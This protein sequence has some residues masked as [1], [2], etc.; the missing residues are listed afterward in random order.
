[1][2]ATDFFVCF[3]RNPRIVVQYMFHS[4]C[5]MSLTLRICRRAVTADLLQRRRLWMSDDTS[6]RRAPTACSPLSQLC[7]H[8]S[9]WNR[10]K[11]RVEQAGQLLKR[12]LDTEL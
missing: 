9:S 6:M 3:A 2:F 11:D 4:V 12:I 5:I 1:M 7:S 8:H 10:L